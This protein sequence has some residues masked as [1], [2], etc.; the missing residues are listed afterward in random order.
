MNWLQS[1]REKREKKQDWKDFQSLKA[2]HYRN[3][4]DFSLTWHRSNEDGRLLKLFWSSKNFKLKIKK[5]ELHKIAKTCR[6]LQDLHKLARLAQTCV[7]EW[8]LA[9]YLLV[10][11]CVGILHDPQ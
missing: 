11:R 4:K 5:L 6:K 9:W 1:D 2:A 7:V 10:K 8:R 3:Q